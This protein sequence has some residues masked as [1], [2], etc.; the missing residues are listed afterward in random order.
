MGVRVIE[1]FVTNKQVRFGQNQ[2]TIGARRKRSVRITAACVLREFAV[3]CFMQE[4]KKALFQMN[5]T[6]RV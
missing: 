2:P 5:K 4:T 1:R 6:E 3:V